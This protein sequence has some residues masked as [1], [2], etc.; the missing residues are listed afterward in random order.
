[1]AP[2]ESAS[3]EIARQERGR[4]GG[5]IKWKLSEA[6]TRALSRGQNELIGKF[7]MVTGDLISIRGK[8][9]STF[10]QEFKRSWRDLVWITTGRGKLSRLLEEDW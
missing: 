2:Y 9:W 5:K 1:M 4:S 10:Q 7:K 3:R 8:L 6:N